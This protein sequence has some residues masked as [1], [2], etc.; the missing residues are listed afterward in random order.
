LGAEG[1]AIF[2]SESGGAKIGLINNGYWSGSNWV[3][4]N[5]TGSARIE[6]TSNLIQFFNAGTT[7]SGNNIAF[8][9]R[10]RINAAG[11][12]IVGNG[13]TQASPAT[14]IIRGC[15]GLGTDIAGA[16]LL[17]QSGEGTGSGAGGPITFYTSAAG[18]SG[19]TLR[20]ATE[21]GRF[22]T[23]GSF[24]V[25][26]TT[27]T[28]S[29]SVN[30]FAVNSTGDILAY[31]SGATA[32]T[33]NRNTNDGTIVSLRQAGTEEGTISVSGATVS[34]NA[35]AG[36]HWSQLLN[37]GRE[38]I[39]RGTVMES[40]DEMCVWP[41]ESNERLPKAKVSDTAGSPNVYGVFMDWDN[42]WEG[43]NDMYVTALGSFICRI[44]ASVTV[45]HGDLL[46]SNG[47]GT[48][49]V[50]ADTIIRSSTIGKVTSTVKTHEYEDGTY[51]VPVVL[52]C[53]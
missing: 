42:D 16:E 35:F 41:G 25:G 34:Y 46:E 44:N 10:A 37:G 53:G 29:S 49:R 14:G 36:S 13:D 31:R 1:G 7:A 6:F 24:L 32:A 2:G 11:E 12:F 3:S 19:T 45:A 15:G 18:A 20:T 51:C 4:V 38:D 33:F 21:R 5:T 22:N 50:Q 48:A 28:L 27:A 39:L 23:A 30:G 40:L 52:Y 26:T 17:I 43:T 9:E 47:D 8:T